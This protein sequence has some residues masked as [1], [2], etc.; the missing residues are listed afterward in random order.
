MIQA[1]NNLYSPQWVSTD[2]LPKDLYSEI[3]PG[4]FMGGTHDDDVV[5]AKP[6]D[7][8]KININ[9]F[10]CVITM[11]AW[12]NPTD[13]G[14][15]EIRYG[16]P[17]SDINDANIKKLLDIAYWGYQ[18]WLSGEKVLIRCQAGLNRSGLITSL[19]LIMD[20]LSPMAVVNLIREK[21]T[22]FALFNQNYVTWLTEQARDEV[23]DFLESKHP[24][25]INLI[26]HTKGK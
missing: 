17:D 10:D 24:S 18:R 13:W 9:K 12:A 25:I 20:G 15:E 22:P 2:Q 16:I 21:R 26:P 6:T 23:K 11:Y 1:N 14:V 3:L 7:K 19:I 8:H 4:L 5:Y